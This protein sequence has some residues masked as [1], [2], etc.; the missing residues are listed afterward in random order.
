MPA[1][2]ANFTD[3]D[4]AAHNPVGFQSSWRQ[5]VETSDADMQ[6]DEL[7]VAHQRTQHP[8]CKDMEVQAE[9]A[10]AV[11]PMVRAGFGK[12]SELDAFLQQCTP[13]LESQLRRNL[14]SRAFE[15]HDVSWEEQ[16]DQVSCLH[17]LRHQGAL[18]SA[19]PEACTAVAWNAPGTVIAAAY[20]A[21]D[22]NDWPHTPSMLCCWSVF[23]RSLDPA[24]AD[25]AIELPGCLTCLAFH[26]EDPSLLAGGAYNGD[27]FLWRI[28]EKGGDP[29]VAK[30]VLT[31]Y[32]HHEPVLQMA[33]T[34]D[35]QRGNG[36]RCVG[37][38]A[39]RCADSPHAHAQAQRAPAHAACHLRATSHCPPT[40]P[41]TLPP[42]PRLP[43]L[44][45]KYI[46]PPPSQLRARDRECGRQAS[47]VE[48]EQANGTALPRVHDTAATTHGEPRHARQ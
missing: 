7:Q 37:G 15:G 48:P 1:L 32:T 33:W 16:H 35:P 30:S 47:A 34:R 25:V 24:K 8:K 3:S 13:L 45:L 22:R 9:P 17:S 4:A 39:A 11:V 38:G 5:S 23:R 18:A 14:T 21:L 36:A 6:T 46:L 20:G 29:L 27:V 31:N 10:A 44:F 19:S 40:G 41:P 12:L 26:P 42:S 28:G 43:L 2:A